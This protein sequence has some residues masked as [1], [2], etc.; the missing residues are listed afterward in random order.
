MKPPAP[1][2]VQQ[3]ADLLV[4]L[5]VAIEMKQPT[6]PVQRL[7][8]D[9]QAQCEQAAVQAPAEMKILLMN[10]MDALRTWDNVWPVMGARPEFRQAVAREA[11]QWSKRI[12][13]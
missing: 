3:L 6:S 11:R 9:A 5:A 4:Q 13:E 7:L 2:S 1:A 8:V 10:F 12:L